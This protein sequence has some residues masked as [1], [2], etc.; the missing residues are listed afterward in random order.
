M[1]HFVIV[2]YQNNDFRMTNV[3]NLKYVQSSYSKGHNFIKV[4]ISQDTNLVQN[5]YY[6]T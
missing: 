6:F 3:P 5:I 1:K 2:L 4:V